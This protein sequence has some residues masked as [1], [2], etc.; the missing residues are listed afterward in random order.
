MRGLALRDRALDAVFS[1]L[2]NEH[3]RRILRRLA[4]G[5]AATARIARD[6]DFSKQALSRHIAVLEDAGLVKRTVRGRER[7]LA[8]APS[9][10]HDVATWLFQLHRGWQRSFDRLDE[11]L[12]NKL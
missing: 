7:R 6:F 9:R 11:V 3:R 5:D 4:S 1:A 2:A 12:Q 8:L 10:L